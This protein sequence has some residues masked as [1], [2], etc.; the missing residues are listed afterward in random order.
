M[1]IISKQYFL[2]LYNID[3]PFIA[4]SKKVLIMKLL[5]LI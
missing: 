2:I 5:Y 4:K 3:R 1:I